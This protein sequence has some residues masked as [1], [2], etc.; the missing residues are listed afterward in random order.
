MSDVAFAAV[1]FGAAFSVA[2][3]GTAVAR[4]AAVRLDV[5]DHPRAGK[6][7]ASPTPYLGGLAILAGVVAGT[8]LVSGTWREVA[9]I[10]I[11]TSLLAAVG[12]ADD[13]LSLRARTRLGVQAIAAASAIA[14]GVRAMPT[15]V[16]ALDVAI[17]FLWIVGITNAFNLLD[18]MDGLSAGAAAIAAVVFLG[19]A[20]AAGQRLVSVLAAAVAGGAL[21]FLPHNFPR[22]RIFM[23]DAGSLVLGFLLAILAL[24]VEFEVVRPW[25]F[26]AAVI[27]LG[28]PVLDTTVVVFDRVRTGRRVAS[29]STDH[30]SHRLVSLGLSRT[31][32]VLM[33]LGGATLL[34]AVGALVGQRVVPAGVLVVVG[35]AAAL[36]GLRLLAVPLELCR[37]S[38]RE[39]AEPV[40]EGGPPQPDLT[41]GLVSRFANAFWRK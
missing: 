27:V 12:L 16:D 32:A 30:L 26:G 15:G 39:P 18:N 36:G 13:L 28:L 17:T 2:F 5:L 33:L 19:I 35:G 23:G 34:G 7:H 29:G 1:G 11:G 10:A 31:A 22:A 8:A 38:W 41:P 3:L 25:S 14:L 24:K 37:E 20:A 4:R 9:G 40:S 6:S 21:G